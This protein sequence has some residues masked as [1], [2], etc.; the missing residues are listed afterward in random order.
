MINSEERLLETTG[1][2]EHKILLTFAIT[3]IIFILLLFIIFCK[4]FMFFSEAKQLENTDAE[5]T[6]A[7]FL[8]I[9]ALYIYCIPFSCPSLETSTQDDLKIQTTLTFHTFC[10]TL[11]SYS[12][13]VII[14]HVAIFWMTCHETL[15]PNCPGWSVQ[16]LKWDLCLS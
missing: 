10:P 8:I 9:C 6:F 16:V 11:N 4:T 12:C 5:K 2:N 14:L 3:L 1:S 13:P 15:L 7:R